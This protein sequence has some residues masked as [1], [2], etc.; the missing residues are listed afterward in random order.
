MST[1]GGPKWWILYLGTAVFMGLFVAEG[2]L[3][4]SETEHR[5]IEVGMLLLAYFLGNLWLSANR[6]GLLRDSY[7]EYRSLTKRTRTEPTLVK[8][9]ATSHR[10][11]NKAD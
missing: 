6:R 10:N 11:G 2:Q 7:R 3:P 8:D 9:T 4:L 5:V 1:G